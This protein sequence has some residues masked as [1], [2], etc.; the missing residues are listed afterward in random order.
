MILL[1]KN[2]GP[3]VTVKQLTTFIESAL[4]SWMPFKSGK[5][6]SAKILQLR[7]ITTNIHE[8]HGLVFLDD[9][10]GEIAIK[11]L[12]RTKF[13]NRY[14]NVREYKLRSTSNDRRNLTNLQDIIKNKQYDRRRGDNLQIIND[15]IIVS[16]IKSAHRKY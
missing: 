13:I 1:V 11:K 15:D 12:N 5:I 3:D 7:D 6:N 14:V 10:Y 16:A 9:K 4:K 8:Y 2:I